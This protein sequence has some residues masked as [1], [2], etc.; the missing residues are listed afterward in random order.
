MPLTA[1]GKADAV[2]VAEVFKNVSFDMCISSPYVRTQ[3]TIKPTCDQKKLTLRTDESLKERVRGKLGNQ[4][5]ELQR[6]R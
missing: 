1:E 6:R 3:A 5:D 4:G 2:I